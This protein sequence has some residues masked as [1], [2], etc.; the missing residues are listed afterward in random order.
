MSYQVVGA[1]GKSPDFQN[2]A[3]GAV[4]AMAA[5]IIAS[6]QDSAS[7]VDAANNDLTSEASKNQAKKFAKLSHLSTDRTIANLI[8]LNTTIA[9]NPDS[10]TD[11][12]LQYQ[13]KQVWMTLVEIG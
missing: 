2:R 3:W 1:S 4:M 11:S 7:I 10:A 6:V 8:L 5:D 9:A 13:I 12:D